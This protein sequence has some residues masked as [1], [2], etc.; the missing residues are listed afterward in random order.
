MIFDCPE[1]LAS[2]KQS[3]TALPDSLFDTIL[4]ANPQ[5][6][7]VKYAINPFMRNDRGELQ[8]VDQDLAKKQW[9]DLKFTF[10]RLGLKVLV[11]EG[12]EGLP[13]LVFTANQ[14]FPFWNSQTNQY[15]IILSKM[16]AHE[17][18]EEVKH[19]EYFWN[20]LGFTTHQLES[21]FSF[22][23]N[24][25][26]IYSPFHGLVFGGFGP[27]TDREVYTEL[28]ERFSL[29]IIRLELSTQ[30]FYHLDTC[31]SILSKDVA[32]I[33]PQA[34]SKKSRDLLLAYFPKVIEIPYDEN[35]RFFCGNSFCPDGRTV[36]LQKGAQGFCNSLLEAGFAP[37]E[38]DTGEF[39]K[40]GG[41]VFC[42]KLYFRNK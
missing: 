31:F 6:F 23:G 20:Q 11:L 41:S 25:D 18:Q 13:D 42:L 14:S 3:P 32:A 37:L 39:M 40:S 26:A 34:F 8:Q 29:N 30:D 27:R 10:S 17:R 9:N 5:Y 4:M 38:V 15:E 22:E 16:R 12:V 28:S 19:F 35:K 24:G 36:V 2:L 21:S 1:D 7:E 33:Q